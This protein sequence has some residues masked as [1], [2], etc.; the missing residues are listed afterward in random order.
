[1]AESTI[2]IIFERIWNCV[3]SLV[4]IGLETHDDWL[5]IIGVIQARMN[6]RRLPGKVMINLEGNPI[7][8]HIFNRL[9]EC[10]TLDE[11]VIS[12]GDEEHN[13]P[14]IE[15]AKANQIP[16]YVGSESDLID[17]LYNTVQA[18]SADGMVRITSDCP[19]V[20]PALVDNLVKK[21]QEDMQYDIV[22]N[23]QIPTFPH[24]L[25]VEVYSKTIL[26]FLW[27]TIK[28]KNLREW[29]PVYIKQ[30]SKQ[31]NILNIENKTNLSK[32]RLT[33][34]YPEDLILVEKIYEQLYDEQKVFLLED[35]MRLL[36][37]K[38]NLLSINSK[39]VEHRNIDAPVK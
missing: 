2:N 16:V 33:L 26:K 37:N 27:E 12:T 39:Y 6:S 36:H 13:K 8:W 31:F 14:I 11:V 4:F 15:F 22:T 7:V 38:P 9:S 23:C 3:K 24:G 30:N 19:F 32:I 35:V 20:D 10:E 21:F 25:E 18:F 34:D 5:K 1:M 28:D 17:R 29:F